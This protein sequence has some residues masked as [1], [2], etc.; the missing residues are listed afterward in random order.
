M[1]LFTIGSTKK[2]AEKFFTL[3]TCA[4][5]RRILDVRANGAS[6]LNGWAKT[7]DIAFLLKAVADV[8]YVRLP[9]LAPPPEVRA[10][11][12][13]KSGDTATWMAYREA[14]LAYLMERRVECSVPLELLDRGCVLCS[15]HDPEQCHRSLVAEYLRE[16]LGDIKVVHLK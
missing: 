13:G 10:L 12:P 3:L 9:V 2:T 16:K 7:P 14:F 11:H 6:Q 8:D 4:G 1:T 5:V 15:E